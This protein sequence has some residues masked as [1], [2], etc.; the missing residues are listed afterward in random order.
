MPGSTRIT[1]APSSS[2]ISSIISSGSDWVAVTISPAIISMR[3]MAGGV[4]VGVRAGGWVVASR[5]RRYVVTR[6]ETG[7]GGVAVGYGCVGRRVARR[8]VRS[9]LFAA[10][11]LL[12]APGP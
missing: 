1:L 9:Q 7:A 4:R 11:A 10:P 8:G 3:T 2:A 5:R 12:L 6:V